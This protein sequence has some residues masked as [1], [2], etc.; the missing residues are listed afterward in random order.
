VVANFGLPE[1]AFWVG[2]ATL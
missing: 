2:S 1:D